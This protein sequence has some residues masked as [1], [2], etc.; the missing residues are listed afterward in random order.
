[1][2][3]TA[4]V[5]QAEPI[6]QDTLEP[7]GPTCIDA[8]A[9]PE[10]QFVRRR[11][12]QEAAKVLGQ[13]WQHL[14]DGEFSSVPKPVD[15]LGTARRVVGIKRL[16]GNSTSYKTGFNGL[17]LDC[18]RLFSE[19]FR[20]L[21][22]EYFPEALREFE[23]GSGQYFAHGIPIM[24][25]L[26]GGLSPIAEPEEQDRRIN[27]SI[28]E[29]TYHTMPRVRA[30]GH[31]GLQGMVSV[32]NFSECTDWAI[33]AYEADTKSSKKSSYDGYVPE[34][35]KLMIGSSRFVDSG[36]R[37]DERIGVSGRY[38]THDVI[39]AVLQAEGAPPAI[40]GLTKSQLH[41]KQF[42][43][44]SGKGV[45]GIVELLD[46]KASDVSGENIFMGEPVGIDHAKDYSRIKGE[47]ETRRHQLA[48]VPQSLAN[49]L[50]GLVENGTD[51]WVA[52]TLVENFVKEKLLHIAKDDPS[53][54]AAMFDQET[55]DGFAKVNYLESIGRAEE[56]EALLKKVRQNAPPA[57]YCTAGS[58]GLEAASSSDALKAKGLGLVGEE[59]IHDVER[60]CPSCHAMKVFYDSIGSKACTACGKS[61]INK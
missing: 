27:D 39:L 16:S 31:L 24:D 60:P 43:E 38:I 52:D 28:H 53:L 5:L 23:P 13:N 15:V 6:Y 32:I 30:I 17:L 22:W 57:S 21:T 20:K 8:D 4:E 49:Y 3:A 25:I 50:V 36:N 12:A 40:N 2:A 61:E 41:G 1:M 34:I 19:S 56:A 35:R 37:Y 14:R 44:K 42:I 46:K 9:I 58:C 48:I 33:N 47:A 11:A 29:H 45:I 54:A 7:C 51:S 59:L 26:Q 18:E 10:I 55:A